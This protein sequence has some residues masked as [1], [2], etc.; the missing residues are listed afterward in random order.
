MIALNAYLLVLSVPSGHMYNSQAILGNVS[1][2][3]II[4]IEMNTP[5]FIYETP[6]CWR[7]SAGLFSLSFD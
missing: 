3:Y 7:E 5:L 2:T 1:I 4:C 6:K